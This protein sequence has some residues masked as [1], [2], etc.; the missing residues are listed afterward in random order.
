MQTPTS[1]AKVKGVHRVSALAIVGV[2][3]GV[4]ILALATL[5]LLPPK[6]SVEGIPSG[7]VEKQFD[8]GEVVLNY[9]EGPDNGIPL[10]LIP[11]QMESWQGYKLVMPELAKR[12][13]VFSVDLRGHGK[14]TRTPGQYSYNICGNDLKLF[15]ES[16]I[17]EP[18]VV[19]GLSS[20]AVLT[21]WLAANAPDHVRAIVSEDPPMFSSMWPRIREER[22]MTYMFQNLVDALGGAQGR[23]LEAYLAGMGAPQEGKDELAYVPAPIAKAIV[24]LFNVN[25]RLR[26]GRPYDLPLV[27]Y[28]LRVGI[29][30]LL[31]YDVD[32]SRATIDGRL[33]EGFDPEDALRRV[34]CPMLL[35]QASSSRDERW[36]LLGAMDDADVQRIKSL[37][38]D[39]R[40]AHVENAHEIHMTAPQWY[41]EQVNGFVDTING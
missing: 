9:V 39:L 2:V 3:I 28:N 10:L 25:R 38:K 12:F 17:K 16:V 13:H 8:T 21:V 30:F 24:A 22:Y 14:S 33:S 35:L 34:Q 41:L 15:L 5:F 37:V 19:S 27:P 36:G 6:V 1:E 20:G 23:D 40:Y 32:F 7:F 26:P 31:E 29:K 18:A 4:L 11:G